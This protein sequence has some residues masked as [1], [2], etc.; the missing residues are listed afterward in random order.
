LCVDILHAKCRR[1]GLKIPEDVI[2]YIAQTANGSVRDLEGVV[3]SLMAYS[4]VY[5]SNIDMRLAERIIKRAVKVDNHPLTVDD[6]LDKVCSHYN[7]EQRSVFSKS[8]K[9]S[10]VQVRQV[11]M[12]LAQKYTKMPAGRIGQLIGNRDHSTVIH[13]CNAIEQRLKI[14]KTFQDE[15]SSIENSF[16]LKK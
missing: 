9:R 16:K 7:V 15:I 5:N 10:L 14:D 8:R 4:I 3:N 12:Y 13:S 2:D 6:I 11:S 1:D